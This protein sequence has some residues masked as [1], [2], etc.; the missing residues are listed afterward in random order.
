MN[1]L[2]FSD[3]FNEIKPH[4]YVKALSYTNNTNDARDL[5]QETAYKAF[6]GQNKFMEGSN[7]LAWCYTILHNEFINTYRHKKRRIEIVSNEFDSSYYSKLTVKNL[8]ETSFEVKEIYR[9]IN[10]LPEKL[11]QSF[12][13]YIKGH[14]YKEIAE[15]TN[16]PIGTI[17]GFI[18]RSKK[19]LQNNIVR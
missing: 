6:R 18:H 15:I 1:S 17:K 2:Q 5:V 16:K 19:I 12:Y 3:A 11:R 14:L 7:F 4:L 13:L 10:N 9:H 8:A